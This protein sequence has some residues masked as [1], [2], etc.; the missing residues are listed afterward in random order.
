[1]R[2]FLVLWVVVGVIACG[3]DGDSGPKPDTV[4]DEV[5]AALTNQ[6]HVAITFHA[7]GDA[8]NFVC[9]LDAEAPIECV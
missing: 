5:P 1:M 3:D 9:Q 4:L 7:V 2:R 8:N 6:R